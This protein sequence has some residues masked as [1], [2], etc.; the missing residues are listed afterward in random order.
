MRAAGRNRG[1]ELIPLL[2]S[3]MWKTDAPAT[4]EPEGASQQA[5]SAGP[6]A[7]QGGLRT[8][9]LVRGKLRHR[10]VIC[11]WA[12]TQACRQVERGFPCCDVEVQRG[13]GPGN[14]PSS[15]SKEPWQHQVGAD[16]GLQAKAPALCSA[17]PGWASLVLPG[18]LLRGPAPAANG[19]GHHGLLAGPA[20]R[21]DVTAPHHTCVVH[22]VGPKD[23]GGPRE[24]TAARQGPALLTGHHDLPEPGKEKTTHVH[25]APTSP[26]NDPWVW[27]QP[28]VLGHT[29]WP[30]PNANPHWCGSSC[31]ASCPAPATY[32]QLGLARPLLPHIPIQACAPCPGLPSAQ[33]PAQL[34][35]CRPFPTASAQLSSAVSLLVASPTRLHPPSRSQSPACGPRT[36]QPALTLSRPALPY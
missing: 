26:P 7:L 16:L 6:R 1:T 24:A 18:G 23:Q 4:R 21:L 8:A 35:C 25:S 36:Y 9:C 33:S 28:L 12:A 2:A 13:T 27:C 30:V 19:N 34:P 3:G 17:R 10:Q 29:W 20:R 14:T 22:G 15:P 31:L 32:G 5:G 11:P